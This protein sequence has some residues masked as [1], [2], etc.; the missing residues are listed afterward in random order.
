MLLRAA[1]PELVADREAVIAVLDVDPAGPA[2]G[3]SAVGALM[4]PGAPLNS[5]AVRFQHMPYDWSD[6]GRL[7]ELLKAL[8]AD[9]V[10]GVSSEG[11][12]FEYGS[13]EQ[14]VDNLRELR[15]PIPCAVTIVG[16]VTRDSEATRASRAS[17][18]VA[19]IPRSL[20]AFCD[21][22]S[23]AGWRLDSASARPFSYNVRLVQRE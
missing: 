6:A 14:I 5:M 2:F 4:Q 16:S 3:A 19:T 17:T 1:R 11:A 8:P 22:V 18:R 13:D 23:A 12:L 10:W 20:D 7:G 9:A 21:L 15:A